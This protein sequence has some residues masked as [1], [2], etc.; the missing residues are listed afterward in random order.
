ML[1][2]GEIVRKIKKINRFTRY[3]TIRTR[4]G[5]FNQSSGIVVSPESSF[6]NFYHTTGSAIA[7]YPNVR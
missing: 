5:M 7:S 4:K 1:A 3:N 2:T 6:N